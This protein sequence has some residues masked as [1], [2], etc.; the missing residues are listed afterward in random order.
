MKIYDFKVIDIDGNETDLKQYEGKYILVVNTA[1]KC[2]LTNQ[3]ADL[4]KLY[5]NLNDELV[6]LAFPCNQFANQESGTNEE[7]KSFCLNTYYVS[8]PIFEKIDVNGKNAHPL[9]EYLK[10]ELPGAL[11]S[12][13]IK[14]NFT[15]FLIDK[16]GTPLK[17]F[18]PTDKPKKI[19]KY[20]QERKK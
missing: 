7:I 19:E 5:K 2:G 4:E 10:S 12:T 8:F 1:S 18:A 20:I 14:W 3:Y 16:D 11:S 13:V 9:Y 17:R 6:I 15:K